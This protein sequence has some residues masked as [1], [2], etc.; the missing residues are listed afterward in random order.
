MGDAHS[1]FER[2]GHGKSEGEK[3]FLQTTCWNLYEM[4][5][6]SGLDRSG[7]FVEDECFLG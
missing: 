5:T 6:D 3:D 7:M 4:R 2:K 1:S